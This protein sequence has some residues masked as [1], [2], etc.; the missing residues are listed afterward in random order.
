VLWA[1]TLYKSAKPMQSFS[2]T[3]EAQ[4]APKVSFAPPPSAPA[5]AAA[6]PGQ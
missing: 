6:P 4:A 2:A 5:P 1:G 3:S